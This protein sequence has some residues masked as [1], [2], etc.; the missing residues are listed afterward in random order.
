MTSI[1]RCEN[2]HTRTTNTENE[3]GEIF[4]TNCQQNA[5]E[6]AYER[7][8]EDFHDGGSAAPWPENERR[9]VEEARKLK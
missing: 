1:I 2:C 8:C 7:L 4:C 5:A 3:H 6:A 9:R